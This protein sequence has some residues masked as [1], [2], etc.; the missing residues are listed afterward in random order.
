MKSSNYVPNL[1]RGVRVVFKP[2]D[3]H[4]KTG[5]QCTI[6][7]ILPNPSRTAEHQWYDVRFDDDDTTGRFLEKHLSPLSEGDKNAA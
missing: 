5:Q 1:S 7:G 4:P 3:Y 6:I 2:T